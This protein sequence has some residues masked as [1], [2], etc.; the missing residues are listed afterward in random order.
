MQVE[1]V[2]IHNY[3]IL[4]FLQEHLDLVNSKKE[5]TQCGNKLKVVLI[6]PSYAKY[7]STFYAKMQDYFNMSFYFQE[8]P[9]DFLK[10]DE[11][12]DL[13]LVP[14][15]KEYC[16]KNILLSRFY[17]IM[18]LLIYLF[19]NENRAVIT[20]GFGTPTF[21]SFIVSRFT[22]HKCILWIED[23]Y[24][25]DAKSFLHGLK[26]LVV[27]GL[28]KF[29][30]RNFSALVVEGTAQL[31]YLKLLEVPRE[32]IFFSNHCSI[33]YKEKNG[34]ILKDLKNVN[35]QVI[36]YLGRLVDSKGVDVLIKAFSLIEQE[37][38]D[39]ILLIV[40]DGDLRKSYE[41]LVKNLGLQRVYFL[42]SINT[43]DQIA[44]CFKT[45]DIFVLPSCARYSSSYLQRV[46]AVRPI[47][48]GWGLVIN[49]A[50]SMSKP[51]IATDAVGAV[52]DLVKDGVNG[53]VVRNGDV[54][55][56]YLAIRKLLSDKEL[57][58]KM[59]ISSRQV[60]DEFNDFDKQF[61]GFKEAIEYCMKEA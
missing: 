32:N 59:G 12:I 14:R 13:N 49:E 15:R 16:K 19:K 33:D 9:S 48:E 7:R 61:E 50:M 29:V 5:R 52:A 30:M 41:L 36:L 43:A 55:S 28:S 10:G 27:V 46:F 21:I 56:L 40:G 11:Q 24:L 25:P 23:W 47:V 38:T 35:S 37:R 2:K 17:E 42:G 1:E 45:S 6:H 54:K 57:Q 3:F 22:K 31:N 58:L 39:C 20:E 51:I 8:S 18:D 4:K 26:I 60:F 53:L 44:S 34:V